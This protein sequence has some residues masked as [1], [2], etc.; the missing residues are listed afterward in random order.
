MSFRYLKVG[1]KVDRNLGG[2]TMTLVVGDIDEEF[3]WCGS[4][5]G[6]VPATRD[7]GWKFDL[8]YGVETDD[9]MEWGIEYGKVLS[10]LLMPNGKPAFT[11]IYE[12]SD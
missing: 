8:G 11:P 9:E 4:E 7:H 1:D 12:E 3:V 2:V 5:N 6:I 10:W